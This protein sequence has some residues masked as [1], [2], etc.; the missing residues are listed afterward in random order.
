M[1]GGEGGGGGD[2]GE[3]LYSLNL[4][5]MKGIIEKILMASFVF[6]TAY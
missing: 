1:A 3:M 2:G 5:K 4:A 6:I